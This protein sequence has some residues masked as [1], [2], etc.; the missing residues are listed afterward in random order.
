MTKNKKIKLNFFSK[1]T[2]GDEKNYLIE[3]LAMLINSGVGISE[4]LG[5]VSKGFRS[6]LM[7]NIILRTK[8]E[9]EQGMPLWQA[10]KNTGLL[11]RSIISL[12]KIGEQSGQLGPNLEAISVQQQKDKVS[13]SR[14]Q[15][16]M[17]YPVLVLSVTLIV[18]VGIFWFVLPKLIPIFN[19]LHVKLPAVTRFFISFSSFLVSYGLIFVPIFLIFI[20]I[21]IYFVFINDKTKFVGQAFLFSIPGVKKLMREVE[22]SRFGY[23]LGN[24]LSAGVP[25]NDSLMALYDSTNLFYYKKLYGNLIKKIEEGNSFQKSFILSPGIHKLIPATITQMI[26]VGE[27]SGNLSGVLKNIGD[28]FEKKSDGTIKNLTVALEPILLIFVWFGVMAVALAVVLPIYGLIGG[29]NNEISSNNQATQQII[30][31][32]NINAF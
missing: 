7:R 17:A 31:E 29:M 24:L 19:Q 5:I 13:L 8:E 27:Q 32:K 18:A 21:V 9:V 23:I 16:A 14:I 4:S 11:N 6:R 10:L 2:I 3:N 26:I 1:I 15:S 25:L 30:I 28:T 20:L 12:V 22:I